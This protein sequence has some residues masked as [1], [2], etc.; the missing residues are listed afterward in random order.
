MVALLARAD[1]SDL[2]PMSSGVR[3]HGVPESSRP[4]LKIDSGEEISLGRFE[5]PR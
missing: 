5:E 2:P 1:E 3:A 4:D